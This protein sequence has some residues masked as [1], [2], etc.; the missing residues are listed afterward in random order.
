MKEYIL[1]I[2]LGGTKII[3]GIINQKGEVIGNPLQVPTCANKPK[4]EIQDKIINL[5]KSIFQKNKISLK[6]IEGIGIGSPGPLDLAKGIILNP[7]N[8]PTL[9]NY[10]IRDTIQEFFD[11]PVYLNNDGNCFVL[12]ENYFGSAR[13]A[14]ITFGVTLG[15]GLGSG[16]VINKKIFSG[17]TGT[18]AEIWHSPYQ[19]MKFEDFGSAKGIKRMYKERTNCE[20]SPLEISQKARE[21]EKEAIDAYQEFGKHLGI[22]L[23]YGVNLIDPE[24]IVIG[25]SISYSYDLFKDPL[26]KNLRENI[27]FLPAQKLRIIPSQLKNNA[28]FIG[29]ACLVLT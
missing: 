20:L 4:E 1:G 17:A 5:I 10:P 26:E 16:L 25:G 22:I 15:T 21:G 2:D 29:A 28:G 18:A 12:G 23:S 19:G 27:N 24:I 14:E 6:D 11:V 9:Y 7:P 8:L 13:A 3:A